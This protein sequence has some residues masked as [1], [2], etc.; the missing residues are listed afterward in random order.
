MYDPGNG[1]RP[2]PEPCSYDEEWLRRYRAAQIER[3][4]RLDAVAETALADNREASGD[5]KSVSSSSDRTAGRNS[6]GGPCSRST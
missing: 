4:A 2:W 3:V 6:G 5:L 1:W